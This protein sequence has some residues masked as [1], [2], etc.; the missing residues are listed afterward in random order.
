MKIM[1]CTP[2]KLPIIAAFS[3][4]LYVFYDD[5]DFQ[6]GMQVAPGKSPT[7]PMADPQKYKE[8]CAV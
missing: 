2:R 5:D 6:E 1:L 3:S 4:T 8:F 7:L